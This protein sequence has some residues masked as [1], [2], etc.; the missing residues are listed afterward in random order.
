MYLQRWRIKSLIWLIK[1][2]L[3]K[4]AIDGFQNSGNTEIGHDVWIGAE[5]MIMPGN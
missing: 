2:Q 4:E 3:T 5:A 1:T